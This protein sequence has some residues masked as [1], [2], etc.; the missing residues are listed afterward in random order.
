MVS[1]PGI[2]VIEISEISSSLVI[3]R[4]RYQGLIG[5]LNIYQSYYLIMVKESREICRISPSMPGE[6]KIVFELLDADII[7]L[8]RQMT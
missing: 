1:L 4:R 5:I 8:D 6:P 3:S 7:P 2:T